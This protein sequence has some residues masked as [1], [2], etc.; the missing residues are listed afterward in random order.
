ML[1]SLEKN[2]FWKFQHS[3]NNIINVETA[4]VLQYSNLHHSQVLEFPQKSFL[5]SQSYRV[6]GTKLQIANNTQSL[7][8]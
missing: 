2:V 5:T 1:C 8:T 7:P 3:P 4:T 6:N